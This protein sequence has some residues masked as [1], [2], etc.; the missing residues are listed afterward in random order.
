MKV[1]EILERC[2]FTD[3]VVIDITFRGHTL[4]IFI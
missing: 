2:D 1:Y 4:R 3:D